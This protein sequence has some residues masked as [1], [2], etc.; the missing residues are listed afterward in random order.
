MRRWRS[1]AAM[2]TIIV[3]QW[4]TLTLR[5]SSFKSFFLNWDLDIGPLQLSLCWHRPH[6]LCIGWRQR[7]L[8]QDGHSWG[9]WRRIWALFRDPGWQEDRYHGESQFVQV[10]P[11]TEPKPT[12]YE[13]GWPRF[14]FR[15]FV[16][17]RPLLRLLIEAISSRLALAAV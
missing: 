8:A 11:I 7:G 5:P 1:A 10:A 3:T 16:D 17:S 6:K 13:L 14:L 12:R 15:V 2:V 9:Y 4:F